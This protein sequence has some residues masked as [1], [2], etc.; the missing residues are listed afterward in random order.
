M[1]FEID[2]PRACSNVARI[3]GELRTKRGDISHGKAV[4]KK[5]KSDASLAKLALD[6]TEA[7]ARYMFSHLILLDGRPETRYSENEDFNFELDEF[8]NPIGSTP[9][10][11]LLF[12]ND[13]DAYVYELDQYN[14]KK[15]GTL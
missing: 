15:E 8:G 3:A 11:K 2:L 14:A 1:F 7:I 13:Y 5:L 10:S 4:S 9:Y 6:V 12:E